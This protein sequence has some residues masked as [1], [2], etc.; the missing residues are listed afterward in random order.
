MRH[1]LL[2]ALPA[3]VLLG[4]AHAQKLEVI[5]ATVLAD[6]P[7]DI[8][9]TGFEPGATVTL[10]ADL[11]DGGDQPWHSEAEFTAD[12][13]GEVDTAKQ[14]PVKG[15][16]RIVSAMGLVWS[17]SPAGKGVHRGRSGCFLCGGIAVAG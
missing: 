9:A 14:A 12:A 10:V 8:R 15:S 6:Q 4:T 13:L 16:Y 7:A 3:S 2:V 11:T 1:W 17:M 5:P